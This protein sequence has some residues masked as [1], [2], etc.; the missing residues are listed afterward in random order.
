MRISHGLPAPISI[1]AGVE[2][3]GCQVTIDYRKIVDAGACANCLEDMWWGLCSVKVS[4]TDSYEL[5]SE[6]IPDGNPCLSWQVH[7]L[8][9]GDFWCF[10]GLPARGNTWGQI[11][12]LYR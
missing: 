6:A 10:G 5:L 3:Y 12:S 1:R 8:P 11:K 9:C 7:S 4:G 2:Y